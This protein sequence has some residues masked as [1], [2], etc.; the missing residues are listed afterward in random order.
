M[1]EEDPSESSEPRYEKP[2]ILIVDCD[3]AVTKFL[4]ENRYNAQKGTF[5]TPYKVK[6]EDK[7][8]PVI[9][10]PALPNYSEQ[11][12][13]IIDL[14]LPKMSPNPIGKK[15]VSYGTE[16]WWISK[17][18]GYVDPRPRSMVPITDTF[19]RL[20]LRNGIFI[21]FCEPDDN[22]EFLNAIGNEYGYIESPTI[23]DANIYSFLSIL[24]E[25][26]IQIEREIGTEIEV[27]SNG[28][29]LERCFS[30]HLKEIKSTVNISQT[31]AFDRATDISFTPLMKNKYGHTVGALIEFNKNGA[32]GSVILLPHFKNKANLIL[33]LISNVLPSIAPELFPFNEQNNWL[34]DEEYE[35]PQI[36]SL[37]EKQKDIRKTAEENI[38][39]IEQE[40]SSEREQFKYLHGILTATGDELVLY[41]KSALEE[42][43]FSDVLN[44]DDTNADGAMQED[45][46]IKEAE[47]G[48]LVEVKGISGLPTESDT[49]QVVKYIPRRIKEWK[50]IDIRGLVIINHQRGIPPLDRS[51]TNVFTDPQIEDAENHEIAL[52]STWDLFRL[53]RAKKEFG[54]KF[55]DLKELF[56]SNGR[57]NPIPKHWSL[58]GYVSHFYDQAGV[59]SI[60]LGGDLSVG[61]KLGY[62]LPSCYVEEEVSSMQVDKQ[63][64]SSATSGQKVGVK[65]SRSRTELRNG[66]KVYLVKR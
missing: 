55:E 27:I 51:N 66:L 1:S 21:V 41:V 59:V 24:H 2:K 10:T 29:E 26:Y 8:T 42:L 4:I 43:G 20:F 6:Q 62:Q 47:G 15:R 28:T 5:G 63:S 53:L 13:V 37:V 3:D 45:L 44:A 33:D 65:T 16:D 52:V 64:V 35:H 18:V 50:T 25:K 38:E 48:I 36:L 60:T 49:L 9:V 34:H 56:Y 22:Q 19:D 54:W 11:E 40:I 7:Y 12:I 57:V 46:Q 31:E 39:K 32:G 14:T 58:I 23:I 30:R 61:D 17:N